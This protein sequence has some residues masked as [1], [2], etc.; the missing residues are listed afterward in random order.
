MHLSTTKA[1]ESLEKISRVKSLA[2]AM[3]SSIHVAFR[4]FSK[5]RPKVQIKKFRNLFIISNIILTDT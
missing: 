5:E 1:A 4:F 2:N 3:R